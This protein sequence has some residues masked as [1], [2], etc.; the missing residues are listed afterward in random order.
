MLNVGRKLEAV[1]YSLFITELCNKRCNYCDIPDIRYPK[2][3]ITEF[4][5]TYLPMIDKHNFESYTLTGGEPAKS[6]NVDLVF[7]IITKP[8]KVNTNGLFIEKGYF[9]KYYDQ[10][11][12][13]SIHPICE[14][15]EVSEFAK[16][17]CNDKKITLY[18][19]F[20]NNNCN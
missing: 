12:E 5:E 19:P 1:R 16:T 14:M 13:L 2:D 15:K 9:D 18:V 6:H 17:V 3:S 20:D 7:D 4:I 10:I 8:I 11:D